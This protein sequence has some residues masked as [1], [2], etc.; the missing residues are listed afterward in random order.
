M[1]RAPAWAAALVAAVG[2]L[3]SP[4]AVAAED[5]A[6]ARWCAPE[7]AT[8]PVTGMCHA[9]PGPTA[10]PPRELVIFLHGV[11]A[12]GGTWQWAQQRAAARA[13][14]VHGVA[15]LMPQGRRGLR[16]DH[17]KDWYTWPTGRAAQR[18]VEEQVLDE[19]WR[20]RRELEDRLGSPFERVYLFGF[21][22]GAY[23][24]SSL[25]LRGRLEVDGYAAF[26]GGTAPSRI[27]PRAYA[28]IPRIPWYVGYGHRDAPA[29]RGAKQLRR[30]FEVLRWP[31][32]VAGRPR[33]GHAMTDAQVRE[34]LELLRARWT[35]KASGTAAEASESKR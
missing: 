32:R 3:V 9:L 7:L 24:V 27:D 12:P 2:V 35:A 8:L 5:S 30:A 22:N 16:N 29:V 1:S 31:G 4:P 14:A 6:P 18:R 23:Y 25:A 17:M 19:W 15:A 10:A 34:A 13:A 21:S 28:E 33:A 20:A 11:I 26:A